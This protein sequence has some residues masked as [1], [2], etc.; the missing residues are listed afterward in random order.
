MS[1]ESA[2]AKRRFGRYL[3]VVAFL[4]MLS[5]VFLNYR[6]PWPPIGSPELAPPP[7][8]ATATNANNLSLAPAP[9]DLPDRSAAKLNTDD[10]EA[11]VP[12]T[13]LPFRLL[14][15]M[16]QDDASRSLAR[17]ADTRLP[18]AQMLL[19]DQ[20]FE[21]R[22]Q[23]TLVAIEPDS[24][25]LDNSGSLERLPLEPGGLRLNA[26]PPR[27]ESPGPSAR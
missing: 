25:L 27:D 4:S 3:A 10:D 17:I 6:D 24:V 20:A 23:V 22:P 5:F 9:T 15:T 14:A 12:T 2:P 7:D 18:N 13:S 16:V 8:A 21:G 11:A 26:N 19:Q 1:N